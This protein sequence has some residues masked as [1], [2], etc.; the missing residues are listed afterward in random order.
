MAENIFAAFGNYGMFATAGKY[1]LWFI[2]ALIIGA[3]LTAMVILVMLKLKQKV[4]IELSMITRRYEQYVCGEKRNKSGRK[5]LFVNKLRKFMPQ[6]QQ[7]DLFTKGKKDVIMLLKDNNGLHHTL[8]IPTWEEL[9]AW[10]WNVY[11]INLDDLATKKKEQLPLH[12]QHILDL[13]STVYLLPNPAEDLEWLGEQT[14][15]ADKTF[16]LEWWKH[17][18]VILI[19]A[20]AMSAFVFIITLIIAKKM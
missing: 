10:Y 5:Q 2:I 3:A 14:I 16:A 12:Q 13:I 17:P 20:L 9:K 6:I 18:N 7:E 1:I 11:Q 19:G 4:V 8:R 15:Q